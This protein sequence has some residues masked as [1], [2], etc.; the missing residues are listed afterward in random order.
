[1][2]SVSSLFVV[3]PSGA[4]LDPAGDRDH[5]SLEIAPV[6]KCPEARV[7][8]PE[9]DRPSRRAGAVDDVNRVLLV[10]YLRR[11][12]T[13][14]GIDD[15]VIRQEVGDERLQAAGGIDLRAARHVL[16][17]P[18]HGLHRRRVGLSHL[19]QPGPD[20]DHVAADD[21]RGD[22]RLDRRRQP[23]PRQRAHARSDERRRNVH[24]IRGQQDI[25]AQEK[26]SQ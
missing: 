19:A 13:I 4:E 15:R 12:E 6:E 2:I 11:I 3:V 22:E 1:M 18:A 5:R 10:R 7:G 16:P 26:P 14:F 21:D 8:A 20:P 24:P 23:L 9:I 25:G 17:D